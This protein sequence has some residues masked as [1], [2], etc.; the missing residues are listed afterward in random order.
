MIRAKN[1]GIREAVGGIREMSLRKNL[2]YL[3]EEH[4]KRTRDRR[5]E[6]AYIRSQGKEEGKIEGKK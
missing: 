2:R 3:Y 1:V 5:G 6:D 4:L